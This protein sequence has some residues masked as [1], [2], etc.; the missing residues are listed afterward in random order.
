MTGWGVGGGEREREREKEMDRRWTEGG[1]GV[2]HK[3]AG[4]KGGGG[5]SLRHVDKYTAAAV[6]ELVVQRGSVL[7]DHPGHKRACARGIPVGLGEARARARAA[8]GGS[9]II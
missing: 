4:H 8:G 9:V 2:G 1:G 3:G 5:G 7:P 6:V